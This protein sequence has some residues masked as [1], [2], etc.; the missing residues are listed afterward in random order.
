ML[1]KN[2]SLWKK[3]AMLLEQRKYSYDH[4][5]S[6]LGVSCDQIKY[7]ARSEK[8]Y[9]MPYHVFK[10][11]EETFSKFKELLIKL[12][13]K[14]L[15]YQEM[16]DEITERLQ[17][18]GMISKNFRFTKDQI[19]KWRL[20]LGLNNRFAVP[21]KK[22]SELYV[23]ILDLL[24][25]R[26]Y[27]SRDIANV[28][29]VTVGQVQNIAFK[30]RLLFNSYYGILRENPQAWNFFKNRFNILYNR[31]K[32]RY[33]D[34]KIILNK[35]LHDMKYLPE[36]V[37][38][39][40]DGLRYIGS[41]KLGF[42][43]RNNPTSSNDLGVYKEFLISKFNKNIF[44]FDEVYNKLNNKYGLK[45]SSCS[46]ILLKLKNK[47]VIGFSL[48]R[49]GLYTM[50]DWEYN[51]KRYSVKN[52]NN[53][54]VLFY[55]GKGS[56]SF[57][58]LVREI[59]I[60]YGHPVVFN[61]IL[62]KLY[63]LNLNITGQ[64]LFF[65]VQGQRRTYFRSS[66]I[67]KVDSIDY[68]LSDHVVKLYFVPGIVTLDDLNAEIEKKLLLSIKKYFNSQS[69]KLLEGKEIDTIIKHLVLLIFDDA[70]IDYV[71]PNRKRPDIIIGDNIVEIKKKINLTNIL[72]TYFKYG[73][74]ADILEMWYVDKDIDVS[75]K[76][77]LELKYG[78]KIQLKDDNLVILHK[79]Y[80]KYISLVPINKVISFFEK[81]G[82]A[83]DQ[84]LMVLIED[85]YINSAEVDVI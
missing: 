73:E 33:K 8:I 40:E 34:I 28:K 84:P 29:G 59:I 78:L 3:I 21:I 68:K 72:S 38:L 15:T 23:D 25:T 44:T 22:E 56:F 50:V 63:D 48:H 67:P 70:K 11:N 42:K 60:S 71:L 16:A 85:K 43:P 13:I 39:A 79:G 45:K 55:T 2:G 18:S 83:K 76:S 41:T 53:K 47:N 31:K 65:I 46:Q 35:E 27:T 7:V 54:G 82:I 26:K 51:N 57:A 77:S 37:C 74:Y 49:P 9:K 58:D 4:I 75:L 14:N 36:E 24:K 62:E 61:Q 66:K 19:L 10:H 6:K 32:L 81:K 20:K 52:S 30:E 69:E 17:Q 1:K 12:D 5:S 64:Y 80:R